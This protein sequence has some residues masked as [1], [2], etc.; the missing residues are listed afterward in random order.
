MELTANN[1]FTTYKFKKYLPK[2]KARIRF[3]TP[4]ECQRLIDCCNENLKRLVIFLLETGCRIGET[5]KLQ[6]SDVCIDEKG[7]QYLHL[8]QEITK[9]RK[10]RI[11]PLSKKAAEQIK[12]Q[13]LENKKGIEKGRADEKGIIFLNSKKKAYRTEPKKAFANALIRAGLKERYGLFHLLRHTAGSL[14]LQGLNVD[15]T[16]RTPLKIELIS[17]ILGHSNINITK[18]IY[19]KYDKQDIIDAFYK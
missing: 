15:G 10:A 7:R 12:R 17:E 19:A 9:G 13:L 3:L 8:R 1:P 18:S 5:L 14:W 4:S 2:Y 16:Q 11:A 6:E